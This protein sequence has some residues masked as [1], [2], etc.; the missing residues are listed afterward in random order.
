MP[1][2]SRPKIALIREEKTPPDSRVALTPRQAAML[3]EQGWDITVQPSPR[4]TFKDEE[5]RAAGVPLVESVAD[6]DLLL[7]IK[8]VP[9]DLLVPNKTYCFFAHVIK[10]QPYNRDLL[11]ALLEKNIRHIDYEV[12]TDK[13]GRRKI[14]FGY[15]AGMVGAHNGLWAYGKRTGEFTLPRMKDCFDYAAVVEAYQKT[16][17]PPVRI[18]LTGTGRVGQGAAQVLKDMGVKRVTPKEF[19]NHTYQEAVFTQLNGEHYA[20]HRDGRA[21]ERLHFFANPK[22]Y[23]SSAAPFVQQCDIFINGIYWD[24]DAPVFFTREEML[25]KDFRIKTIA[26]VTCDIAPVSSIPATLKASTIANPVFGYDP[27]KNVETAP[28]Q[29]K[30]VDVMSIDNLPS[31]LP[32]DASKAFGKMFMEKI[33]PAFEHKSSPLLIRATVTLDGELGPNFQYLADYRDGK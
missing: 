10:E 22:D 25:K 15:F 7:G 4:R 3:I 26:D 28:F 8:E 23:Q 33:L 2:D 9:I 12:L 31:E 6:R 1:T 24:N 5:Y 30:F 19:L 32:R 29:Q 27:E 18:V 14:A 20:V 16:T 13:D 17:L 11:L 21:F